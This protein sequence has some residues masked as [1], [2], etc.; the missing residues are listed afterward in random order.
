VIPFAFVTQSSGKLAEVERILGQD[1]DHYDLDLPEVQSVEVTN[2]VIF[3]VRWAYDELRKPVM[4]E[5]TGLYIEAWDGLPGALVKWFVQR[6]GDSGICRMMKDYSNRR[7]VAET[8][9]ATYDGRGDPVTF[10]GRI[11]GSIADTPK[12]LGG[13]GWDRVF[14]PSDLE[15]TFGEMSGHE[16]DK[17]SMRCRAFRNMATHYRL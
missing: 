5:D 1:L 14:I 4:I 12:G 7:A 8:V 3:K 2:V 11:E 16:K 6:V 10:S 13:F 15:K 9:V 17:Y